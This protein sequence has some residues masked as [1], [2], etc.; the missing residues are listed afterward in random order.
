VPTLAATY[1]AGLTPFPSGLVALQK[2]QLTGV[3]IFSSRVSVV[4]R[5]KDS[6]GTVVL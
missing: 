4:D 3:K 1:A 6:A 5:G 2:T